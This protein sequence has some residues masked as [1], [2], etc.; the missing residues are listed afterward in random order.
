VDSYEREVCLCFH[1]PL[2]KLI[3]H[4]RIEEPKVASQLA[5]C[6]GAGTG[7][8][9]CRP[10]LEHI[11]REMKEG[12][13]PE[14]TMTEE[15]YHRLRREYHRKT[16]YRGGSGEVGEAEEGPAQPPSS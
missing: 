2:G 7:C 14:I 9:W 5:E 12:R 1:V 15:E 4:C 11:F 13:I 10:F 8:G 6:Y 3:K 16:G